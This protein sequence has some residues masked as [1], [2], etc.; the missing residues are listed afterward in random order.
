MQTWIDRWREALRREHEA[1]FD[2][3]TRSIRPELS[4][5]TACPIC[6]SWDSRLAFVKDWFRHMRCRSCGLV[7]VSPRLNR[8]AT[9]AYYNSAVNA[10]YNE[11]KFDEANATTEADD[12]LNAANLD[13]IEAW[14]SGARGHLLEVGC[15][16]GFFLARARERGFFVSGLE[17]NQRNWKIARDRLGETILNVDL[18]DAG[19]P[20]GQFDVVYSRDVIEHIPNPG[21]FLA[22]VSRVLKPT[23]V[24]LFDTHNIDSWINRIVKERHTV[25][26]GF[27]HPVH[28]SPRTMRY[29]LARHGFKVTQVQFASADLTLECIHAYLENPS[30]TTIW[31]EHLSGFGRRALRKVLRELLR[32]KWMRGFGDQMLPR[33]G[34]LCRA[35]SVMRI[36]ARKVG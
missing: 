36:I 9:H 8:Q 20:P 16:K 15:A 10:V 33:L 23:G 29:A 17:L 34:N 11:T 32:F 2:T 30:F 26:F 24:V 21:E 6:G 27:E 28:W 14:T 35:G 12:R 19:F 25:I 13:L 18:L 4:E 5:T 7:Y 1:V 31:P 22:E 3:A